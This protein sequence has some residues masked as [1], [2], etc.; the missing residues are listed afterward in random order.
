MPINN[1]PFRQVTS[2]KSMRPMLE[3]K[4]INPHTGKSLP[5]WALIDSGA[6]NCVLPSSFA[7]VLGHNL[8]A[9][10]RVDIVGAGG[11][12]FGYK[13]TM[14]MEIDGFQTEDVMI[15]FLPNL[16]QPLIGVSS[17]LSNFKLTIDYPKQRFSLNFS[18]AEDLDSNPH[19]WGT[20]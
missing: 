19:S 4:Y 2:N 11:D 5:T 14:K 8:E 6:D 7:E 16:H 9:G 13:H 3:V 12:S 17:F 18:E 10:E 15:C 20:P 1:Y